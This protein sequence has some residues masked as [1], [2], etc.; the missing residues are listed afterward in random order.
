MPDVDR[1]R[2]IQAA[3]EALDAAIARIRQVAGFE[4]FLVAPTWDRIRRA[5]KPEAP[6]VYLVTTAAGSLALIVR[7][8]AERFD[9]NS[10]KQKGHDENGANTA[11]ADSLEANSAMTVK[12]LWLDQFREADLNNLL[13]KRSDAEVTGGY[14]PGQLER[15]DWLR[16]SLDEALPQ[17]GT[18]LI[19]PLAAALRADFDEQR[20][21]EATRRWPERSSPV[22][23]PGPTWHRPGPHRPAEP[24]T[25]ARCPV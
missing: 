4:D 24:A 2:A 8:D 16:A 14:L 6:L 23:R 12:V 15:S 13:V 10:H 20:D 19:G 3:R 22:R 1:H 5:V 25:I 7:N 18:K 17:L 11:G 21:S 9:F